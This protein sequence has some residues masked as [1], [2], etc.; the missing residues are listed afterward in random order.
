MDQKQLGIRS[1]A[2]SSASVSGFC[3]P[4]PSSLPTTFP[5]SLFGGARN[6]R[7][8]HDENGRGYEES[9]RADGRPTL[10]DK[11]LTFLLLAPGVQA[12]I[13]PEAVLERVRDDADDDDDDDDED[14]D[15]TAS[16]EMNEDN[17]GRKRDNREK[18][19]KEAP[20]ARSASDFSYSAERY[21]GEGWRLV[22]D[23]GGEFAPLPPFRSFLPVV[24]L[25]IN[26]ASNPTQ[27]SST[28]SSHRACTSP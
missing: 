12:L 28:R 11:Y 26:T 2:A 4:P 15:E 3:P 1:R 20:F 19:A 18:R 21:A 23:A 8:A 17:E 10:A 9:G 7:G 22:G 25:T 6:T 16:G 13:G 24:A 5:A 14:E 27:R